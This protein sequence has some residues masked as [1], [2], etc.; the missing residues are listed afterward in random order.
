MILAVNSA[1]TNYHQSISHLGRTHLFIEPFLVQTYQL[2]SFHCIRQILAPH[3]EGTNFINQFALTNLVN[4][5]GIVDIA[6]AGDVDSFLDLAVYSKN[7]AFNDQRVWKD[8][9]NRGMKTANVDYPYRDDAL[10]LWDATY[11][12]MKEYVDIK[13][14]DFNFFGFILSTADDAVKNDNELQKWATTLASDNGG[15]VKGFG[16]DGYSGKIETRSY[17]ADVLTLIAFQ[18]GVQHAGINFGQE[19]NMLF[20]PAAPGHGLKSISKANINSFTLVEM[21]PDL[22]SSKLWMELMHILGSSHYT[23]YG[24]YNWLG[25]TLET[26]PAQEKF[27]NK[28]EEIEDRINDRNGKLDSL[29]RYE[30]LK[31]STIPMSINV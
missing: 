21:L 7:W 6:L 28:L 5:D 16:E 15:K 9:E 8:L 1:D 3:L 14:Q 26:L 22:A 23:E 2:N 13:Y 4:K 27:K 25:L 18:G 30:L 11:A 31:P 12:F 20:T 10:A 29:Y 17:L 19:K 24:Q